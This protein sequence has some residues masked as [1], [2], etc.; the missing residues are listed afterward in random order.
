[1]IGDNLT[2]STLQRALDGTWQR[3]KAISANI[4]NHE[5]PGYKA[6]KVSFE[7]T[8]SREVAKLGGKDVT[9]KEIR[10]NLG[11]IKNSK[12]WNYKD[13]STSMRADGNN[14]DIDIENIDMVKTQIQYMY[15]TRGVTDMYSR[16]KYAIRGGR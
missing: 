14:V 1:M 10:E 5:T 12:I 3:Q 9:A 8:L 6:T 7:E 13:D 2:S 11:E 16:L 4:A 15:L